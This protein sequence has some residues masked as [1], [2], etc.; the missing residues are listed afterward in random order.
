MVSAL[1]NSLIKSFSI[2]DIE[3]NMI[4]SYIQNNSIKIEEDC[5]VDQYLEGFKPSPILLQEI[6][7]IGIVTIDDISIAMELLIPTKDKK[8]NG[9]F[10]TPA[11]I[12]DYILNTIHPD[13]NAKVIDPSCGS[14]AFLLAIARYYKNTYG[15]S[16]SDCICENIYGSDILDYNIKRC[17]LLLSLLAISESETISV[18]QMNLICCDSLKYKW[19]EHFDAVVGN[20]PYVK[21]QD[22]DEDTRTFLINNY[23]T[24]QFGTY[25]LYFAFFELGLRILDSKGKLGYITPNNYFTSLAGESLRK[26]FCNERSIYRIIDFNATKVFEVQTYTAISFLNKKKNEYIEYDRIKDGTQPMAF[27]QNLELTQN[28]YSML[29]NSKWRLLCGE[30]RHNIALIE[31]CGENIGNLFN[32]CVGIATLK[33][34]VYFVQP[35]SE[36]NNYYYITRNGVHYKI[37]KTITRPIVKISDMKTPEDINHN[38]RRIIFPYVSMKG[39]ATA[40]TEDIMQSEYPECY[41]YLLSVKE[42]LAQRGKG[43]HT[44][45]PFYA[46]GRTQGL[47]RTGVKLLTPTFSKTP[48]FLYDQDQNSFFT[49]GYGIY[50]RSQEHN[51]FGCNLMAMPENLDVMQ[52]ILNS[53]VM[54]YYVD[55]TSVAIEGGYPCYQ[56]NFIERFSVPNF[57][58]TEISELRS[59][60][61]TKDIN[62][63]LINK[64]HLKLPNPNRC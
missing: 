63:Y 2:A 31:G 35:N 60:N 45:T 7:K 36:D 55:K 58:D 23:R 57:T 62:D 5:F 15:K 20:P 32:I 40:I 54:E 44:Y 49:N 16:T 38:T 61:K 12:A 27:L 28:S 8:V 17:K 11:Y 42:I 1:L 10:F 4:Y 3:K 9:A 30:E 46:Y 6:N 29:D 25:N 37:E 48:R 13:Y 43:K 50:L 39:K 26:F 52:K 47:N 24:T 14:G 56:K 51:L 19:Q 18:S 41:K 33:D 22:M 64:Y 59:L 53:I 34:E 21:F